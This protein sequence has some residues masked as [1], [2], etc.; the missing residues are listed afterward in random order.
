[1]SWRRPYAEHLIRV[2][3][4]PEVGIWSIRKSQGLRERIQNLVMSLGVLF[5]KSSSIKPFCSL[6]CRRSFARM[7][8]NFRRSPSM[9][10]A[11]LKSSL[12]APKYPKPN[13]APHKVDS[14]FSKAFN[15]GRYRARYGLNSCVHLRFLSGEVPMNRAAE[16]FVHILLFQCPG[17]G[18]P[19]SSAIT[20]T[21]R[22]LGE[23]DA[24]SLSSAAIVDGLGLK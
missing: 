14:C 24:R 18:N 13:R 22:N 6:R 17:C 9:S 3:I 11:S 4:S 23:T 16:L 7:S 19:M 21:E 2:V 20:K 5:W 12:D 8:I 15:I 1:M 10:S